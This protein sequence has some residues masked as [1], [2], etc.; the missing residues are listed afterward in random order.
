MQCVILEEQTCFLQ[1][2]LICENSIIVQEA[3]HSSH[4]SGKRYMIIKLNMENA[5]GRVRYN[6]LFTVM[7]KFGFAEKFI[8]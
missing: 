3:V 7:K 2:R 1:S 4:S 6:F 5:F 8:L